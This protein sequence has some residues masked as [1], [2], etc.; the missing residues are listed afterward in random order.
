[1]LL[2]KVV[3]VVYNNTGIDG[4]EFA[5]RMEFKAKKDFLN[6]INNPDGQLVVEDI[7]DKTGKFE[8]LAVFNKD[9]WRFWKEK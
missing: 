2:K 5:D 7:E 3:V 1:M 6:I 8:V 4:T 9:A